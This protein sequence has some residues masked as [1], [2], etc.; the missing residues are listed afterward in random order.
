MARALGNAMS[1]RNAGHTARNRLGSAGGIEALVSLLGGQPDEQVQAS[2]AIG[3]ATNGSAPVP[4]VGNQQ[5]L[6][7]AGGIEALVPLLRS[8]LVTHHGSI[9]EWAAFALGRAVSGNLALASAAHAAGAPAL[10]AQLAKSEKSTEKKKAD[11]AMEALNQAGQP[12][13][14]RPTRARC[15]DPRKW[16]VAEV[17]SWVAVDIGL[18]QYEINFLTQHVDGSVLDA[19]TAT[20]LKECLG[21]ASWGHR[22]KLLRAVSMLFDSFGG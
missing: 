10:L 19:V 8:D 15:I 1:D 17:G 12:T 13:M 5:R 18:P 7:A 20:V 3:N 2:F 14:L 4:H 9:R 21:I 22:R 16:S 6:L 11:A